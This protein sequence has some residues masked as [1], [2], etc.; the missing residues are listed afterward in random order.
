MKIKTK[1]EIVPLKV[2]SGI[3][4]LKVKT[5]IVRLKTTWSTQSD[6]YAYRLKQA[7]DLLVKAGYVK[8]HGA[9]DGSW[10]SLRR[11]LKLDV[12]HE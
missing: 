5:E 10:I 1:T 12:K 2:K 7:E 9:R 3:V 8:N 6:A 4:P 11:V